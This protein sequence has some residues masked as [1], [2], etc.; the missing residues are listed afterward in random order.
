MKLVNELRIDAVQMA[1]P[2]N[3]FIAGMTTRPGTKQFA[4]WF[5]IELEVIGSWI[6]VYI[7]WSIQ[8][9]VSIVNPKLCGVGHK[10]PQLALDGVKCPGLG[11]LYICW[12]SI[13]SLK[14]IISKKSRTGHGLSKLK[15][16]PIIIPTKNP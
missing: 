5:T 2:T 12:D 11:N 13:W 15:V 10:L 7:S 8:M 4:E 9:Y 6:S 1:V 3:M 16:N 14:S